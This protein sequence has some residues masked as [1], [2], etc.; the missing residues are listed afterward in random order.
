MKK[1]LIML[2]LLSSAS[3]EAMFRSLG[4]FL[5]YGGTGAPAPQARPAHGIGDL[6][7]L[8]KQKRFDEVL[9]LPLSERELARVPGCLAQ[10]LLSGATPEFVQRFRS[11]YRFNKTHYLSAISAAYSLGNVSLYKAIDR[12]RLDFDGLETV[13][14][15]EPTKHARIYAA[16]CNYFELLVTLLK[17]CQQQRTYI[18]GELKESDPPMS[19]SR[20]ANCKAYL[21]MCDINE[22]VVNPIAVITQPIPFVAARTSHKGLN[23]L[24]LHASIDRGHT[25]AAILLLLHNADPEQEDHEKDTPSKIALRLNLK[26]MIV[27]LELFSCWRN[28]LTTIAQMTEAEEKKSALTGLFE[29]CPLLASC[30]QQEGQDITVLC[31]ILQ[32]ERN[33]LVPFEHETYEQIVSKIGHIKIGL[34]C[35]ETRKTLKTFTES[36]KK[37][38]E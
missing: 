24:P 26:E 6:L 35:A 25:E 14:M 10:A 3:S 16:A 27:A 31:N 36:L 29:A 21:R 4:K 17:D 7:E 1:I 23:S 18:L 2:I 38:S 22:R 30:Y 9:E 11:N 20:K 15:I 32:D 33:D 34:A 12:D 8:L 19:T 5:D 37:S 28:A 13:D